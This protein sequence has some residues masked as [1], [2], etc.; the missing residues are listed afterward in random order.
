MHLSKQNIGNAY[1]YFDPD[2]IL[3]GFICYWFE[4]SIEI[5][6]VSRSFQ[7]LKVN[8]DLIIRY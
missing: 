8:K 2:E 1:S 4:Y 5:W 7:S 6:I 3:I